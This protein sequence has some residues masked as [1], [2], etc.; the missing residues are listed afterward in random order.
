MKEILARAAAPAVK[1]GLILFVLWIA[2][3]V[4]PQDAKDFVFSFYEKL[5]TPKVVKSIH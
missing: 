4:M 2:Y 3:A 5:T 1:L